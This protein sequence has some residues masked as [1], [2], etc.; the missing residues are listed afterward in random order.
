MT[1][2][3]R[4]GRGFFEDLAAVPEIE[5]Q[6]LADGCLTEQEFVNKHTATILDHYMRLFR[7]DFLPEDAAFFAGTIWGYLQVR[8]L[9]ETSRPVSPRQDL[10]ATTWGHETCQAA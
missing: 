2:L 9:R 10:R 8:S 4:M 1:E 7:F 6:L 5:A 3:I